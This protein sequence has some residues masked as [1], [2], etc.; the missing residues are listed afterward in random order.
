[1]KNSAMFDA[2]NKTET[3][4]VRCEGTARLLFLLPLDAIPY[5]DE[6]IAIANALEMQLE[7]THDALERAYD[8]QKETA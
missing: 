8:T 2:L 7:Q 3:N 6:I 1:M 5:A 4:L